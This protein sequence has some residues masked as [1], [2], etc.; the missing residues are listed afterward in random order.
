[1]NVAYLLLD[2]LEKRID[3]AL[4]I[5]NDS[6]RK[7]SCPGRVT[8]SRS[9]PSTDKSQTTGKGCGATNRWGRQPLVFQLVAADFNH[10]NSQTLLAVSKPLALGRATPTG[11]IRGHNARCIIA[12]LPSR[13][14][15]FL[16]A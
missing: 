11:G 14:R 13:Q 9:A 2:I 10:A 15:Q 16:P 6:D 1:M 4:V 7:I 12:W 5:S 8:A 3:A